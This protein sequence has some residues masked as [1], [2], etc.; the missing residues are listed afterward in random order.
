MFFAPDKITKL[1]MCTFRKIFSVSYR[2]T[3][4]VKKNDSRKFRKELTQK[5]HEAH[6]NECN[7]TGL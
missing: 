1:F 3:Q 5:Q 6:G 2:F 4:N 7:Y